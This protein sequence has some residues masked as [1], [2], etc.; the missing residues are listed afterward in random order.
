MVKSLTEA[1]ANIQLEQRGNRPSLAL[2]STQL[3]ADSMAFQAQYVSGAW[4]GNLYGYEINPTT[5]ALNAEAKW[6]AEEKLPAWDSRNVKMN[7]GGTL[8]NFKTDGKNQTGFTQDKVDYL[9][10][11]RTGETAGTFRT[12]TGILGDI[13]NSQPVYAASPRPNIF[14]KRELQALAPTLAGL[15]AT[16]LKT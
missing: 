16:P 13:I 8:K 2:N 9:L 14:S 4:T 11:K 1:F 3:E 15:I 6:G 12:R 5:G 10:G 7:D